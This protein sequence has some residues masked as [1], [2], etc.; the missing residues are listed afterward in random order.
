MGRCWWWKQRW[1]PVWYRVVDFTALWWCASAVGAVG[2]CWFVCTERQVLHSHG[3]SAAAAARRNSCSCAIRAFPCMINRR[4]TALRVLPP[5]TAICEMRSLKYRSTGTVDP[6]YHA[7][8]ALTGEAIYF[9]SVFFS[10]VMH[11]RNLMLRTPKS[12][13]VISEAGCT[14]TWPINVKRTR[15]Y[16]TYGCLY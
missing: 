6:S 8:P 12:M 11:A 10:V 7:G 2:C 13:V 14:V 3:L 9:P 1:V 15:R 5:F 16:G 4:C